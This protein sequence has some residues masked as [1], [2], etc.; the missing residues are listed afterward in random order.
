MAASVEIHRQQAQNESLCEPL[1]SICAGAPMI[2]DLYEMIGGRQT[3][4]AATESFYKRVLADETLR[5]FFERTDMKNLTSLQ[6]M[7]ISMLLGG[8]VVYTGKDI[9]A[10]HAKARELGLTEAH[11]DAFLKHFRASLDEAGV[12]GEHA[13]KVMKLLENKRATVLNR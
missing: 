1:I 9:G 8:R 13:E 2:D 3:I 7:F 4:W 11:F 12:K 6:S 5:P 10:A